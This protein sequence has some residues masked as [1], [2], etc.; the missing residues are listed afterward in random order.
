MSD[1]RAMVYANELERCI[2]ATVKLA[3]SIDA[4]KRYV[5]ARPGKAHPAWLLGH[6]T[7]ALDNNVGLWVLNGKR[8]LPKG[9]G[10]PFAPDFAG[11]NPITDNADDY[12]AWDDV[13]AEYQKIGA[14]C[15][16]GIR[17]LTTEQLDGELR[18][19]VPEQ[20]KSFFGNT[21]ETLSTMIRHDS[22][23]RGQIAMLAGSG[24]PG[25]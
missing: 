19:N 2:R 8:M 6:L 11:G 24:G 18:G 16:E 4:E 25:A 10:R 21:E 5:Q 23:H 12:P 15:V 20:F 17:A 9:W 14:A 22:H 3:E 13:L 7:S 1:A